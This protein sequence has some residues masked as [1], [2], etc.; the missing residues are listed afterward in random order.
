MKRLLNN[1]AQ[2][3]VRGAI[4]AAVMLLALVAGMDFAAAGHGNI[5]TGP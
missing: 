2:L 5:D 1:H 3:F 4:V